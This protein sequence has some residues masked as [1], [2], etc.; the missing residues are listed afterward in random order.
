MISSALVACN[1]RSLLTLV[2]SCVAPALPAEA[3]RQ[4]FL[5]CLVLSDRLPQRFGWRPRHPDAGDA[6]TSRLRRR[7]GNSFTRSEQHGCSI[8]PRYT[9]T[10]HVR[11][12]IWPLAV[13]TRIGLVQENSVHTAGED[14][15]GTQ[16]TRAAG[17]G[18][19]S[20]NSAVPGCQ[21]RGPEAHERR[22]SSTPF[23]FRII[24][25]SF[26]FFYI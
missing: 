25:L 16:A 26:P 20:R 7:V 24:C 21:F 3:V 18:E 19:A 2:H 23:P 15:P 5:S 10:S 13:A 22:P 11:F 9:T 17:R 6:S 12:S 14:D 1:C 8:L 4:I